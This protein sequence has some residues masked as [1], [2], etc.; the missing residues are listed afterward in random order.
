MK[1]RKLLTNIVS[2]F[3]YIKNPTCEARNKN[4]NKSKNKIKILRRK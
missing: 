4:L 3:I 2:I 1:K